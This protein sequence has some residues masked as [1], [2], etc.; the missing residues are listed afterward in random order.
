M[1]HRLYTHYTVGHYEPGVQTPAIL[2]KV[3]KLY[4]KLEAACNTDSTGNQKTMVQ[5]QFGKHSLVAGRS[6]DNPDVL[7]W[8]KPGT[9]RDHAECMSHPYVPVLPVL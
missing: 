4:R 2:P 5:G 9:F 3:N 6:A 8:Y 1:C 7:C